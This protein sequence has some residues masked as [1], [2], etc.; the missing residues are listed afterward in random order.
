MC[1]SEHKPQFVTKMPNPNPG[2]YYTY[3][4]FTTNQEQ[5][6]KCPESMP[7][8]YF[9]TG[10]HKYN[11]CV[12]CCSQTPQRQDI[13]DTCLQSH[14]YTKTG[15]KKNRYILTQEDDFLVGRQTLLSKPLA[16]QFEY[17]VSTVYCITEPK[18]M[19][20]QDQLKSLVVAVAYSLHKPDLMGRLAKANI[21]NIE[22]GIEYVQ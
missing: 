11:Y 10:K 12:P 6:Y 22:V 2:N 13:V 14:K 5:I 18:Y 19:T 21:S 17:N 9:I 16:N 4:N 8:M 15:S 3:W 1:Q 20:W 7:H